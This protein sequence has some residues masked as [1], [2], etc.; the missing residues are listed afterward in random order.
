MNNLLQSQERGY[1]TAELMAAVF[2]RD[3]HDGEFG[4]AGA[5]A[6]IPIA[7]IKLAQQT[8]APNLWFLTGPSGSLN[9]KAPLTW[10]TTDYR[11]YKGAEASISVDK[12]MDYQGNL[13][14]MDFNF[15]GGFQIDKYGNLNMAFIGNQKRPQF[16]G[17]GSVGLMALGRVKRY[18]IFSHVHT[19]RV[20]VERVAF[21]S[22]PGFLDG[23]TTREEAGCA[24]TSEGPRLAVTP[25]G[26]FDF[27]E[28]SKAMRIKSVHPGHSVE[29]IQTMTGFGLV[30]PKSVPGTEPPTE[31][32]L[33]ILRGFDPEGILRQLVP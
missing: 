5:F 18:Y 12:T 16:R 4:G 29:E 2:S 8:H 14:G 21:M 15:F 27:D 32:E 25:L 17:P 10:S 24:P 20:F 3:L 26:V 7:A 11:M 31:E 33:D 30:I 22:G 19:P 6:Q 13:R 28:D 1:S 23:K 9:S